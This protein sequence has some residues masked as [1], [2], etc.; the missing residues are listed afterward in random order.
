MGVFDHFMVPLLRIPL[1]V[2]LDV[3]ERKGSFSSTTPKR[4]YARGRNGGDS[5]GH[6]HDG[7][8]PL[9]TDEDPLPPRRETSVM[10]ILTLVEMTMVMA[11]VVTSMLP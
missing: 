8:T 5:A 4:T 10:E 2:L 6:D 1:L 11:C 9:G 7:D 3:Q